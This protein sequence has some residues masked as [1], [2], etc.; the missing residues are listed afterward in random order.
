MLTTAEWRLT[1]HRNMAEGTLEVDQEV[2]IE[3]QAGTGRLEM[4][5]TKIDQ[6]SKGVISMAMRA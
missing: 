3:E 6:M 2:I 5:Q 1:S 4:D